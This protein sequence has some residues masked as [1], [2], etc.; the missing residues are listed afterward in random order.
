MP[1]V[2]R[3]YEDNSKPMDVIAE[4]EPSLHLDA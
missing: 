3:L 2:I 1:A 4:G